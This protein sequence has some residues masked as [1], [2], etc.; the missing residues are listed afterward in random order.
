MIKQL[1]EREKNKL[2]ELLQVNIISNSHN[3]KTTRQKPKSL[4][5]FSND[6]FDNNIQEIN[7]RNRPNLTT[8]GSFFNINKNIKNINKT[9]RKLSYKPRRLVKLDGGEI[10]L[11]LL[12]KAT[13]DYT[14]TF[15]K[16]EADDFDKKISS[17]RKK[18]NKEFN[19]IENELMNINNQ[20]EFKAASGVK[21]AQST[22]NLYKLKRNIDLINENRRRNYED[23]FNKILK[24]LDMQSQL[25]FLDDNEDKNNIFSKTT[26]TFNT[27]YSQKTNSLNYK[28]IS[29]DANN[30]NNTITAKMR[31]VINLCIEIGI[32]FYKF[33]TLIFTELREKHNE[34][35]KL[36]K[37]CNEEEMRF[38]QISKELDTLQKYHNRYDVNVKISLQ[39][40]RENSIKRI[41]ENFNRKE[42][43]YILNIYKLEDEIRN[44]T[45]LL[46]KNKDYYN[47]LKE[48]E[49][50]VEKNKKQ[51]EEMKSL[52]NKEIHE[53]IIQ[54][55]NEK[56]RE[57]ELNNKM[58]D[59]EEII[60]KLKEE[61]EGTKR[62]E[63]ES[64]AKIKKIKMIINERN[65]NI[66]MLNEELEWYIREY[67]KEKFN[68]NNTKTALQILEN[69]IFKDDD[70]TDKEKSK[71]EESDDNNEN[72]KNKSNSQK[73]E[74]NEVIK[75]KLNISNET[76]Q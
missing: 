61:Q 13:L 39:Q 38:N 21:F 40:G 20:V 36:I 30:S 52:Y 47:K 70:K 75:L 18:N 68:H 14:K 37:K 32:N 53:K 51:N 29:T 27:L 62:K 66:C 44:L 35:I 17:T 4:K 19:P 73:E 43:E 9:S 60:N 7:T 63:I 1:S 5:F 64:N 72:N 46:N 41:K 11:K 55:A 6:I 42:N 57:E 45:I 33:L 22:T 65:E 16:M 69:R 24:L 71:K 23:L 25:F 67:Q 49:K 10:P 26:S 2:N 28:S 58:H 31:K 76:N 59:L 3:E 12:G 74:N 34:N 54:N 15:Y 56:D 50:E 8:Y 48:K